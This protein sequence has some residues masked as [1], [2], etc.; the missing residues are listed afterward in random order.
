MANFKERCASHLQWNSPTGAKWT[1]VLLGMLSYTLVL[2][3]T[4]MAWVEV[5]RQQ[6]RPAF[7]LAN[8]SVSPLNFAPP[9]EKEAPKEVPPEWPKKIDF[10]ELPGP[11]ICRL[12]AAVLPW[13]IAMQRE[14]SW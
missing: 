11:M 12:V 8:N 1:T 6:L 14:D 10:K 5:V 3:H 2:T 13:V 7:W 9:E 4:Q